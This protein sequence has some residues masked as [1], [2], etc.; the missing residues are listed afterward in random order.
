MRLAASHPFPSMIGTWQGPPEFADADALQ[1][2]LFFLS[3]R[4]HVCRGPADTTQPHTRE[5]DVHSSVPPRLGLALRPTIR[6]ACL[7]RESRANVP[8]VSPARR[9][10]RRTF[11]NSRWLRRKLSRKWRGGFTAV[12]LCNQ[13]QAHSP[14]FDER[15][16]V[17]FYP[18][19]AGSWLLAR[20]NGNVSYRVGSRKRWQRKP[21]ATRL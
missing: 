8:G 14:Q 12:L 10:A 6:S 9:A 18:N 7:I 11:A 4:T 16:A 3:T 21:A 1:A 17:R 15:V 2:A 5:E 13:V 19:A 20:R